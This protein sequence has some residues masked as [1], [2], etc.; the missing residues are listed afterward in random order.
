MGVRPKHKETEL[1][2]AYEGNEF[3]ALRIRYEDQLNHLRILTSYDL[4]I[5]SGF[6]T[7]QLVLGGW[8]AKSPITSVWSQL[9]IFAMDANLLAIAIG[10]LYSQ[11][12]RRLEVI[13]IVQNI[14]EA[15]GFNE[16]GAYLP[17]RAINVVGENVRPWHRWYIMG[18]VTSFAGFCLV[19]FGGTVAI[20]S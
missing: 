13:S 19:L 6:L 18:V 17:D 2:K 20:M 1:K 9:G 11:Y 16:S 15:L 10:L 7:L 4:R 8:F 5:F 14:S 3:E 12:K